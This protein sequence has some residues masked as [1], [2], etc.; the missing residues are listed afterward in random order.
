MFLFL[1]K[2]KYAVFFFIENSVFPPAA[3]QLLTANVGL[4]FVITIGFAKYTRYGILT[5]RAYFHENLKFLIISWICLIVTKIWHFLRSTKILKTLNCHKNMR[6]WLEL[7]NVCVW[8]SQLLF[9]TLS[10]RLLLTGWLAASG[11]T[12][13]TQKFLY[14]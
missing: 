4:T 9:Q 8:Q 13:R 12:D 11:K 5:A 7:C 3:N 10:Q 6:M 14:F 1:D 2:I